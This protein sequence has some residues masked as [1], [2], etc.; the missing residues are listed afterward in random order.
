MSTKNW[1]R[2]CTHCDGQ[3]RLILTKDTH[4]NSL[5][6]HCDECEWGWRDPQR[7]NDPNAKFLTLNEP[8][9]ADHATREEI[10]RHG[11]GGYA[12]HQFEAE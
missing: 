4:A 11:W 2:T 7:V 5:Y 8:F 1:Y 12:L 3:G 9:E 10:D 6:L